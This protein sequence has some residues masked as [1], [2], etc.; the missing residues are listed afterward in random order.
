MIGVDEFMDDELD[1]MMQVETADFDFETQLKIYYQ[2]IFP[3][4]EFYSWLS[5]GNVQKYMFPHR[6]FSFTLGNDAYLRFQSFTDAEHLKQEL[7]RL[8][9]YKIDIGAVYN[10][11]PRDKKTVQASAFVPMERE[12]VF[13]IDMTDYDDI[14]TCCSGANICNQCWGF[15]TVSIKVLHLALTNDFGFK[16]L[17]W[18][19]SGRRG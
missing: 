12:L 6:E 18:V 9:P 1:Q 17:L 16:H 2:K 8:C 14:R 11:K 7:I 10:I 15:M 19:Y 5:Y 13:D 4:K 3:V